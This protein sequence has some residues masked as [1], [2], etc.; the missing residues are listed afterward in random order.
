[1]LSD[2]IQ[3]FE[4]LLAQVGGATQDNAV[5]IN[6]LQNSLNSELSEALISNPHL[7]IEYHSFKDDILRIDAQLQAFKGRHK[8][9]T[10]GTSRMWNTKHTGTDTIPGGNIMDWEPTKTNTASWVSQEELERQKEQGLC[11]RCR[12][13]GYM[14]WNCKLKPAKRPAKVARAQITRADTPS[15]EEMS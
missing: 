12:G 9:R 10:S 15:D 13:K 7:L 2:S 6:Y 14:I 5:R 4:E 11:L 3:K 1:M 8:L